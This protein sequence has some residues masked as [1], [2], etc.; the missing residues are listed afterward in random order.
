M[1]LKKKKVGAL[2]AEQ[3][4]STHL[5]LLQADFAEPHGVWAVVGGLHPTLGA[6]ILGT[7]YGPVHTQ[8]H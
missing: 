7:K 3:D 2:E 8:T 6:D 1:D 4:K 5:P